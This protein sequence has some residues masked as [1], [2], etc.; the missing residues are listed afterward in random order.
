M[1]SIG[2]N[3]VATVGQ[4]AVDAVSTAVSTSI[5]AILGSPA[6]YDGLSALVALP[7]GMLQRFDSTA[8]AG[9]GAGSGTMMTPQVTF[10]I[11]KQTGFAGRK[12]R[13]RQYWPGPTE[14][15]VDDGGTVSVSWVTLL[16]AIA[17]AQ[18]TALSSSP[19]DGP[20]LL[21]SDPSLAP[22]PI[23]QLLASNRVAT[24]RRRYKR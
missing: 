6:S 21:H 4:S 15:A 9:L 3:T 12:F 16:T 14:S 17:T 13:G 18:M 7:S 10:L 19:W 5:R 1:V 20:V 2:S 23:I 11:K 24:Q 8:G 22:T